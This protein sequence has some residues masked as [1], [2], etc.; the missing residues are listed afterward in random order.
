MCGNG[1]LEKSCLGP[2]A[3]NRPAQIHPPCSRLAGMCLPLSTNCSFSHWASLSCNDFKYSLTLSS[4]GVEWLI[5]PY[6]FLFP[7]EVGHGS[8][9]GTH[10]ASSKPGL[11]MWHVVTDLTALCP[12]RPCSNLLHQKEKQLILRDSIAIAVRSQNDFRAN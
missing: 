11:V 9:I 2:T 7:A 5:H 6:G 8:D 10:R 12:Q 3:H 4:R 1:T